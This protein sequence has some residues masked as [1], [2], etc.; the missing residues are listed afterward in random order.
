MDLDRFLD[1]VQ[2]RAELRDRRQA[3]TVADAAL[4][5]LGERLAGGEPRQLGAQLPPELADA[6][7]TRGPGEPF[8]AD[9]FVRRVAERDGSDLARAW[10]D[11]SAVLTTLSEAVGPGERADL[12]AQ[13]PEELQTMIV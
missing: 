6:I 3:R 8:G 5:V 11:T 13:L 9:E 7:Q 1:L 2:A 10:S 4:S 12:L